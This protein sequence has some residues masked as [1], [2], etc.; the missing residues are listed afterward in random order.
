[1]DSL[2]EENRVLRN[3]LRGFDARIGGTAQPAEEI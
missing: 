2:R 1:M 3:R